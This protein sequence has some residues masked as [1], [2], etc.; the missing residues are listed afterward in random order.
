M[1]FARDPELAWGFYGHRQALY[2]ATVPHAGFGVLVRWSA[3]RPTRVFTSNVDGQ[4]QR[5]GLSDVLECHGSIH[6]P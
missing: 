1:H 5:A 6:F 3:T 2:R 4:F